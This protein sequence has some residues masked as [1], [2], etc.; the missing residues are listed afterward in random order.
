MV[1]WDTKRYLC[2]SDGFENAVNIS[3]YGGWRAY[4]AS[5]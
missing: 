2:E 1:L 3:P 5:L 4:I